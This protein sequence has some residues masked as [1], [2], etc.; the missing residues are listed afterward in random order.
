VDGSSGCLRCS[1]K[2]LAGI[3]TYGTHEIS[4]SFVNLFF[5]FVSP[6]TYA[7]TRLKR[8]SFVATMDFWNAEAVSRDPPSSA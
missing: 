4:N 3:E 6:S 7:D 8:R 5:A 2:F 1:S